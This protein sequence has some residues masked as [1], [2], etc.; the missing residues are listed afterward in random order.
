M[1]Y[2]STNNTYLKLSQALDIL[3]NRRY[4]NPASTVSD[5]DK[6][7]TMATLGNGIRIYREGRM[8]L[9][10]VLSKSMKRCCKNPQNQFYGVIGILGYTTFP[11]DYNM[12]KHALS[13][14]VAK[15]AYSKGN[16]SWLAVVRTPSTGFIQ[17]ADTPFGYV[18]TNWKED[19]CVCV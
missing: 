12:D 11:V 5:E 13:I 2:V 6:I 8:D 10:N 18:G 17:L 19:V 15:Y 3:I 9:M 14:E 4:E 1:I 7:D 16:I